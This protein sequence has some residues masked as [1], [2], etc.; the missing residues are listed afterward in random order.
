MWRFHIQI[1]FVV[2]QKSI[3]GHGADVFPA[4]MPKV[5]PTREESY[6]CT[7]IRLS[8]D[9]TYFII[10]FKPNA[11]QH[12]AHHM[13]IYGCTEPG[14]TNEVWNCGEMSTTTDSAFEASA[15]PCE[16]EPQIIYAWAKGA[17][18]LELPPEVGFKVG[19]GTTIKFLVLQVHYAHL[20]MILPSGDDSGV[21]IKFTDK[22]QPK[23]AG[24]LLLGTGGFAPAH[25]TTF[26]ETSC[27]VRD[28]REIHP[29]AFRTHTHGLGRI[30][31]GWKVSPYQNWTWSLIGKR[32][33]QDPQMFYSVEDKNL[34]I[35]ADDI[36]AARCT[37]V[38][39]RDWEV[40][41]G[42]TNEDE[43]CNFYIMYWIK[44]NG[45]PVRPNSCFSQGPPH[46]SWRGWEFGPRLKNIPDLE[47]SQI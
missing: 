22:Y 42:A 9:E 4:L 24:V 36:V 18:Q 14:S 25:S 6:L 17:P 31:S 38:N 19:K 8:E 23:E 1:L 21:Y 15:S 40:H 44:G 37:M 45:G 28:D 5:I 35:T 41:V 30:V 11:S 39:D 29:F 3:P 47:A 46:W 34:I 33:P 26:F 2:L 43:M 32:S 7:P 27:E 16:T 10:G 20:D 13:L 12:T